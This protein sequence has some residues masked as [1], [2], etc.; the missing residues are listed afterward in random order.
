MVTTKGKIQGEIYNNEPV[1]SGGK[2][3]WF[4]N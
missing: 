4:L 3:I 1:I 2:K